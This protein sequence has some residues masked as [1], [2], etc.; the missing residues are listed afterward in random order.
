MIPAKLAK[1]LKACKAKADQTCGVVFPYLRLQY[2]TRFPGL[3]K[4]VQSVRNSIRATFGCTN[5]V[6]HSQRD[7]Y[8]RCRFTHGA[9]VARS[10][11]NGIQ[12]AVFETVAQ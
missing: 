4:G 6:P 7:A 12:L 11:R 10:R 9:A 2:D 5:S 8:G 1:K 3:P